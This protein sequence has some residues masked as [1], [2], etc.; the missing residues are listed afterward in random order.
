MINVFANIIE[1]LSAYAAGAVSIVFGYEPEIP[2]E[3][4]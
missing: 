4:E 2:D 1:T 3:L